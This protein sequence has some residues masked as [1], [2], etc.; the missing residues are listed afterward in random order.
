VLAEAE[1]LNRPLFHRPLA[2]A[3][4][5]ARSFLAVDGPN[6]ALGAL[7]PAEDGDGLI[8]RLHESAGGRGPVTITPPAG[9]RV[10][11]EVNLLEDALPGS[12]PGLNPFQIRSWRLISNA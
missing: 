1:D 4:E 10:A 7:K 8:L 2:G 9:W 5:G 6:V 11:G 3:A 12:G